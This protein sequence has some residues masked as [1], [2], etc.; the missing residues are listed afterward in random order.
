MLINL[1]FLF[2]TMFSSVFINALNTTEL[3]IIVLSQKEGYHAAQADLLQWSIEEQASNIGSGVPNIVLTHQLDIKGSW[4]VIPLLNHL[5]SSYP[6]AKW[7]FFCLENT[8][9]E[10]SKLLTVLFSFNSDQELWI[11]HALYDVQP[12]IIHH[13]AMHNKKFKYPHFTTGFALTSKL[14]NRIAKEVSLELNTSNDFSIDPAYELADFILKSKK[15][16]KLTH[17]PEL[18]V[19]STNYCA[20]YPRFFH[21]C[22]TK[23]SLENI[24]FAV[25]TCAKYHDKRI[26]IIKKTW[27]KYVV[28]IGY[29]SD[30]ADKNLSEAYVVTNTTEGHCAKTY[31][32]LKEAAKILKS[33]N[34]DWLIISDDDTIFSVARLMGLLTCYYPKIPIAIGERYGYQVRVSSLG[35]DYLTGGA[36]IVLSAPLVYQIINSNACKC[37]SLSV[38]DDMFIFGICLRRLD[39]QLTHSYLFHQA[40]SVDYATAYLATQEPVSFHKFWAIDPIKVYNEWF[41]EADSS[42]SVP[43]VHTEL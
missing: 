23:I 26:P 1:I 8:V 37:P 38:P 25:K 29:F 21:P 18:C 30:Q 20:T 14:L 24:Y 33:K 40:R 22:A 6:N 41:S 31:D 28:N 36:G 15:P 5:S 35:Y 2:G 9:V 43:K 27:A 4:T 16:V 34:L 3:V 32:I 19:V 13:F 12:T 10:L 7:F 11:G 17:V 39:I 42:L